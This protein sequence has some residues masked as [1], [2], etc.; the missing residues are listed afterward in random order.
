M[1]DPI[2]TCVGCIVTGAAGNGNAPIW[3]VPT[4]TAIL[5]TAAAWIAISFERRKTVN[6]ELIKRRLAQYD[7]V[8]PLAND[9]FCYL[10]C[11]GRFRE[12]TP[13]LLLASKREMDRTMYIHASLFTTKLMR[14]YHRFMADCY[15]AYQGAGLSAKLRTDA[16]R[17]QAQ[18][19]AGWKRDWDS[20]FTG[21]RLD[22]KALV[23]S[24][25]D[26]VQMFGSEIG[27]RRRPFFLKRD[28]QPTSSAK[29]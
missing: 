19:G 27:A 12:L 3:L 8:L 25:E 18:F 7:A 16:Q 28:W 15:A 13:D 1:A 29:A 23:A 4:L 20:Y 2:S 9:L 24:Y 10:L 5:T 22:A 26:F 17:L 11:R 6:Q 21:E 14:S